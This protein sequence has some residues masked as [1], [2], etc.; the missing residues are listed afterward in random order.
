MTLT[1]LEVRWFAP[2]EAPLEVKHWFENGLGDLSPPET[3][4]DR[5]FKIPW[6]RLN[7]KRRQGNLELKWRQQELGSHTLGDRLEGNVERWQKWTG[8]NPLL[9]LLPATGWIT[10]TKRRTQRH[11]QAV[12]YE[13]TQLLVQ[14]TVWWSL[15]FEALAN[16][17]DRFQ[18]V[19]T[20]IGQ[21]YP[22]PKLRLEHS[23]AYP[24]WLGSLEQNRLD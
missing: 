21:T 7:L 15:A 3:R 8:L 16:E 11:R 20:Q 18:R 12:S 1:T 17:G 10:V 14:E 5:Y 23:C 2:G 13:L 6:E 4:E 9:A 22:G 19:V 24:Q